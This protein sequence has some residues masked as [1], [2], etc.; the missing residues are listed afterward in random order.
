MHLPIKKTQ[1]VVRYEWRRHSA[2]RGTAYGSGYCEEQGQYNQLTTVYW[3]WRL[4]LWRVTE[5][6]EVP[7]Y[8]W[9]DMACFGFSMSAWRSKWRQ[10]IEDQENPM[11]ATTWAAK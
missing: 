5:R 10:I 2:R 4:P 6:E 1:R 8:V 9:I 11:K 7:S 3:W